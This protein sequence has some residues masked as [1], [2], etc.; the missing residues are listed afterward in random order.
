MRHPSANLLHI[1]LALLLICAPLQN[2]LAGLAP[3]PMTGKVAHGMGHGSAH[4]STVMAH[5]NT[6][7]M[8]MDDTQPMSPDCPQCKDH[9]GCDSHGCTHAQCASCIP[10]M[11]SRAN[12]PMTS[13]GSDV[14]AQTQESFVERHLPHPF[15]PPKS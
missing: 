3:A 12:P 1:C 8:A 5:E 6:L 7:P 10:G 2:A 13:A 4:P 15:R 14:Y 9:G 11:L